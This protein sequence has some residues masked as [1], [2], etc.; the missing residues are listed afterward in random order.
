MRLKAEPLDDVRGGIDEKVEVLEEAQHPEV[1]QD[2]DQQQEFSAALIGGAIDRDGNVEVEDGR[3]HQEAGE[4]P[5]PPSVEEVAGNQ[6]H[7]VLRQRLQRVVQRQDDGEK[8]EELPGIKQ[9]DC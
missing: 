5:I 3:D 6:Q 9:H 8:H 7:P 2:A 4:P 1:H